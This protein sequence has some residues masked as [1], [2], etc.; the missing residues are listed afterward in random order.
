ME[1]D[2]NDRTAG[3]DGRARSRQAP[4][5]RAQQFGDQCR[6]ARAMRIL[7][8]C[9]QG[10]GA[11]GP[12]HP[13]ECIGLLDRIAADARDRIV[14]RLLPDKE[15]DGEVRY[16]RQRDREQRDARGNR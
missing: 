3:K 5:V 11:A 6:V 10:D 14:M 15:D 16:Q 13:L 1:G 9:A 7:D 12:I 2:R 4:P 8:R